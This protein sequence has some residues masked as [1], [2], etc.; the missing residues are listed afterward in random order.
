[1]SWVADLFALVPTDR[2]TSKGTAAMADPSR[3]ESGYGEGKSPKG[4]SI[5]ALHGRPALLPFVIIMIAH[6]F[7]IDGK[8]T[9]VSFSITSYRIRKPFPFKPSYVS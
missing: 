2:G 9:T 1:M 6:G 7:C 4:C 8:D 3:G 5:E